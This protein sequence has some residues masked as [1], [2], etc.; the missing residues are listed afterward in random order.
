MARVNKQEIIKRLIEQLR[1]DPARDKVPTQLA[2]KILPVV[3]VSERGEYKVIHD[4]TA[5][6]SDKSFVVPAG[7]RWEIEYVSFTLATTA[8]VG[9]RSI[10]TWINQTEGG[11]TLFRGRSDN[12]ATATTTIR[13]VISPGVTLVDSTN[14]NNSYAFM[15]KTILEGQELRIVEAAVVDPA[16]DDL[17]VSIVLKEMSMEA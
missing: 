16:A 14:G 8:T 5:N 13:G 7:M 10:E 11:S 3:N 2:E 1:L 15:P 17:T 12:T 4:N 6:D 9:N